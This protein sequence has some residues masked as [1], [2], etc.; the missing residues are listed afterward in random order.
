M[1]DTPE[2]LTNAER[3]RR[4][5]RRLRE[6]NDQSNGV[7]KT[8][9]PHSNEAPPNKGRPNVPVPTVLRKE[10]PR[11]PTHHQGN[12]PLSISNPVLH[13]E[14]LERLQSGESIRETARA[15]GV[16]RSKVGEIALGDLGPDFRRQRVTQNLWEL[17]SSCSDGLLNELESIPP[18]QRSILLGITLDKLAAM[19]PK[20]ETISLTQNN[21]NLSVPTL[22]GEQFEKLLTAATPPPSTPPIDI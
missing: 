7:T 1:D 3:Q 20:P 21:L 6:S 13:A 18:A 15:T 12:I 9:T 16:S 4:Y 8:V 19:A 2:P 5:R 22:T 11:V 17:A 10:S 14:V